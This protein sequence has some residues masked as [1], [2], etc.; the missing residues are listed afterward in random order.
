[1]A[2]DARRMAR[3]HVLRWLLGAATV[4]TVLA[5]PVTSQAYP[6]YRYD[7]GP[8]TLTLDRMDSSQRAGL[9]VGLDKWRDYYGDS[10]LAMRFE[11]YGQYVLPSHNFGLYGGL[12]LAHLFPNDPA[13]SGTGISNLDVGAFFMPDHT[14]D[15]IFRIGMVLPTASDSVGGYDA[16]SAVAFERLTDLLLQFPHV[17]ALRLSVST[18]QQ[19]GLAF[20]RG[21]LGFDLTLDRGDLPYA[22]T[23]TFLRL[24][25]AAGVRLPVLDL[26][27]ELVNFGALDGDGTVEDRFLHTVTV[28]FSTRGIDQFRLGLVFP[29]DDY[30]RDELWILSLGYQHAMY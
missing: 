25:L 7:A 1:M 26:A 8:S 16:N 19:S 3:S 29:L 11:L 28:G 17:T 27:V 21:D 12:A 4:G 5:A 24:N 13:P 9:Q 20:F 10:A 6:Y 2:N 18:V 15:L 14:S 22:H 30:V 23:N